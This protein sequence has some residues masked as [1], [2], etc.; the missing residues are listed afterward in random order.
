MNLL[1]SQRKSFS[2]TQ[3]KVKNF[4]DPRCDARWIVYP[5]DRDGRYTFTSSSRSFCTIRTVAE[6][7]RSARIYLGFTLDHR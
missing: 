5:I 1:G 6:M 3:A 2:G 7:Q 4:G